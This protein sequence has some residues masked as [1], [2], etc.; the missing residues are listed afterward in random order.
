MADTALSDRIHSEDDERAYSL[1]GTAIQQTWWLGLG[2]LATVGEQTSRVA[3]ALVQ[4][5]REVE[6]AVLKPVKRAASGVSE[7]TESAGSRLRR[8]AGDLGDARIPSVLR[9]AARPTREEFDKLVEEMKE[10]RAR[11]EDKI[12][13]AAD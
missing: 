7:A 9:G 12:Q 4:R 6:P 8:M 13:K 3:D 5:G 11:L 1:I 2:L 10:L